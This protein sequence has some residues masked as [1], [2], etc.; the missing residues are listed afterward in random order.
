M[1]GINQYIDHLNQNSR[2]ALSVFLTAGYPQKNDFADLAV[3]V[4]DAGADM[5][6]IGIPFSD[7]V[8]DGPVIQH[9]S[10]LALANGV[11]LVDTLRW[12]EAIKNRTQK[13]VILMGYA[14]SLLSHG[15]P[16]FIKAAN[17]AGVDGLIIP[18]VPLDEYESFWTS[19]LKGIEV[20]LLTTPTSPDERIKH[21][22]QCSE[23][24]VYCVSVTGTTGIQGNFDDRIMENIQ[25]TY[26]LITKN[27]M[28]IGFGISRPDDV[29]KFAPHC[30]GV[31]VGSAVIRQLGEGEPADRKKTVQL[32]NDLSLACDF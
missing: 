12:A 2:K 28:L 32:V 15:L 10:Q 1:S 23:G 4:L 24:F 21:I 19:N 31:I 22:D 30:D 13:P 29:K 9:S 11:T 14:N 25:R 17:D 27:K 5:L 16:N 20:I 18:D 7:P 6:E 26:R 3:E 8:A